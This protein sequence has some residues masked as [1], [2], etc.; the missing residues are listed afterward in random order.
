MQTE[1][2]VA[3]ELPTRFGCS[4]EFTLVV[5]GGKWKTIILCYLNQ[6]PL[7]YSQLRKLVPALSDKVL[8]E[9][10]TELQAAGLITHLQTKGAASSTYALTER[11][12]SLGDV[13]HALYHW[14]HDHAAEFRVEVGEPLKTLARMD[15]QA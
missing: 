12:Q 2:S 10:L 8:T 1:A 9:R 14:G 3:K 7:R 5:L 13:L 4:T 6:R 11:G 15:T